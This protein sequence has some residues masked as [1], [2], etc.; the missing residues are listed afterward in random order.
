MRFCS[1]LEPTF[2]V[3]IPYSAHELCGFVQSSAMLTIFKGKQILWVT[4][5]CLTFQKNKTAIWVKVV[6][7]RTP[8]DSLPAKG[9]LCLESMQ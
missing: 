1:T 7:E 6:R 5:H 8:S 4:A 9:L 3:E 2:I